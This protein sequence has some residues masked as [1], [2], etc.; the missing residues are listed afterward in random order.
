MVEGPMAVN[1]VRIAVPL[2]AIS[3]LQ[4]LFNAADVAV[5]G[6]FASA[7]AIAAVGANTPIINM[8]L[9][10]FTG[11]A[12]GG[13][14]ILA[15]YIG[16]G[17]EK[18]ISGAVHTIAALALICAGIVIVVGEAAARPILLLI[19]TPDNII[20]Q[21]VLYLRIYFFA[22]A[23]A[24]IYNFA[25]AVLRSKGDTKRPLYCLIISGVVNVV[26]N[27]LL[28]AV[29]HLDVA[30]VAIATL[31]SNI[32][33][34]MATVVLLVRETDALR[35]DVRLL[36]LRVEPL[37]GILRIGLPAGIQGMLFSVSNIIIQAG[38]NG[39]GAD[40]IAG[41]TA[42]L[43]FEF[44]AYFVAM[45]FGQTAMTYTG[46]NYGAGKYRR[47]RQV[48]LICLAMGFSFTLLLS[49]CFYIPKRF[50]LGFFTTSEAVLA[51]ADVRMLYVVL[52][53][54]L[55][56]FNEMAAG[57]MRGMGVSIPPTIISICCSC[58]LRIIW[59]KTIFTAVHTIEV[60]MLVYPVSWVLLM[61]S[62]TTAYL[63]AARRRLRAE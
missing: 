19:S 32:L 41:N 52:L 28:V 10:L 7:E 60:L 54:C 18:K 37:K 14:V 11:L 12:G 8:F 38:I 42:A 23:F 36:C 17:R 15:N 4:Q 43:N 29:F 59:I 16:G 63:I 22:L 21:A 31:I 1:I 3:I 57:C 53:E 35:L 34:S 46:Q 50:W 26:L 40:C 51:F 5:V 47:C 24:V 13:N 25:S 44:I 62:A 48:Y 30:G 33:C 58:V 39:F 56:S 49:L 9:T 27:L 45:A 55:T 20:G 61:I 6:R 2:A